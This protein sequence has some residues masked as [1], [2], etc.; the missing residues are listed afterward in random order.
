M[1]K[2]SAR[3]DREVARWRRSD[4]AELVFTQQ[5][6]VLSK[7]VKGGTFTLI[8]RRTESEARHMATVRGMER[9]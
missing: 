4:G 6:R 9:V 1:A 2:I 3:G 7:A 5:G 8:G